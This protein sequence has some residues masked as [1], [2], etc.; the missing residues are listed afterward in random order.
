[1]VNSILLD[2]CRKN[3]EENLIINCLHEKRICYARMCECVF[4]KVR[5]KLCLDACGGY[6]DENNGT[7][8]SPSFPA[9]YPMNKKC[10][11][12]IVAP[13]DYRITLNFTYF[14][15]EGN[16]VGRSAAN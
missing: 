1:M 4:D 14:D 12:Q 6:L 3:M 9:T 2:F 7:L 5:F 13:E 11:W 16:N 8:K 10:I 15:L